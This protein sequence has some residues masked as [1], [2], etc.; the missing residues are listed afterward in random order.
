MYTTWLIDDNV[1]NSI[2][3]KENKIYPHSVELKTVMLKTIQILNT[4]LLPFRT[5]IILLCT[6]NYVCHEYFQTTTS[7]GDK[8]SRKYDLLSKR[9]TESSF[10]ET[11]T[12]YVG[13]SSFVRT[14]VSWMI[15]VV[16]NWI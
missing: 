6:A 13:V 8:R 7:T 2:K 9:E 11:F 16:G 14:H 5:D 12:C 3:T 15:V 4:V 1:L 10:H